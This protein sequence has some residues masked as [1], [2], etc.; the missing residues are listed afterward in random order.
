MELIATTLAR[1]A[2]F[3]EVQGLDPFGKTTDLQAIKELVKRYSFEK[4]PQ[5]FAELD[6]AKGIEL[7]AG[8]C[9]GINVDKVSLYT[10]GIAVDTR[11]STRQL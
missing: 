6:F 10:N 3:F 5:T 1:L 9:N 7:S 4:W 11:S 2:C 8:T